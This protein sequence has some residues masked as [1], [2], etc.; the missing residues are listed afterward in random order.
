MRLGTVPNTPKGDIADAQIGASTF[1]AA[2]DSSARFEITGDGPLISREIIPVTTA[3]KQLLANKIGEPSLQF[4][5]GMLAAADA[6]EGQQILNA[7]SLSSTPERF[8]AN[9]IQSNRALGRVQNKTEIE[10]FATA[11]LPLVAPAHL[12]DDRILASYTR[13]ALDIGPDLSQIIAG[14]IIGK[15]N[16]DSTP[17]L[18]PLRRAA[19]MILSHEIGHAGSTL[20]PQEVVDELEEGIA[21]TLARWPGSVDEL[22]NCVGWNDLPIPGDDPATY[23]QAR[24]YDG[25]VNKVHRILKSVGIDPSNSPRSAA[26][27]VLRG[28]RSELL[29]E[30]INQ[31]E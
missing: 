10:R 7:I 15:A 28:D 9:R 6:R 26:E 25:A 8:V 23:T 2:L 20:G 17:Q 1:S 3:A 16:A 5:R 27:Q 30:F 21:E 19:A 4:L 14:T 29:E 22:A 12:E 24:S 18:A 13:G 11:D 31:P